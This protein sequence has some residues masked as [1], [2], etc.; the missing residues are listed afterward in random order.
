[1][2]INGMEFDKA[3]VDV[4]FYEICVYPKEPSIIIIRLWE[5]RVFCENTKKFY[6]L[7]ATG[8]CFKH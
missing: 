8:L 4:S 3:W 1:M 2:V 6:T 5:V 7:S